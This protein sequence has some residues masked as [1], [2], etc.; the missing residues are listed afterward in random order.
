MRL[1]A[2]NR[3]SWAVICGV[4]LLALAYGSVLVF[5]AFDRY[6]HSDID[7][8]RPFIITMGPVWFIAVAA[9]VTLLRGR[10]R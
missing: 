8:L 6:S 4:A 9:T 5:A 3:L 2:M 10:A 1:V 7:T